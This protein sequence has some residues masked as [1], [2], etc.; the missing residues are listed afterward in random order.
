M[1]ALL[2]AVA[3]AA[4]A[5]LLL[6]VEPVGPLGGAAGRAAA[7]V[8]EALGDLMASRG[9]PGAAAWA[10]HATGIAPTTVG[11]SKKHG[12]PDLCPI[13]ACA[14][15]A[16]LGVDGLGI[17]DEIPNPGFPADN[18]PKLTIAMVAGLQGFP[19]TGRS[20]G[21]R[22]PPTARSGMRSRH[23]WRGPWAPRS[24]RRLT[25]RPAPRHRHQYRC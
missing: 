15:W 23:R 9:W 3:A 12:G 17:A 24:P 11:G 6:A 19:R 14:A 20:P 18:R 8:S 7:T 4:G 16:E 13:R 22:P 21:G 2:F 1:I 5:L 10:R 25:L